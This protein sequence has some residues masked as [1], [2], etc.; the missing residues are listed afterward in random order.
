MNWHLFRMIWNTPAI[1]GIFAQLALI[2]FGIS[3]RFDL[4]CAQFDAPAR[5]LLP[6]IPDYSLWFVLFIKLRYY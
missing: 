6:I 5:S 1:V 3:L 2:E 4:V